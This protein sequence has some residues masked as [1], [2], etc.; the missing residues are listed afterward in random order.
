MKTSNE[1]ARIKLNDC[2]LHSITSIDDLQNRLFPN[3]GSTQIERA[4]KEKE[5]G[6]T[7]KIFS[8]KQGKKSRVVEDPTG[9]TKIIHNKVYKLI[10]HIETPDYLYS[11]V[12][13]KSYISNAKKHSGKTKLLKIDIGSFYQ[14]IKKNKLVDFFHETLCC[15][16]DVAICL[17]K[18]LTVNDH[19]S[20]GSPLSPLLSFWVNK[21]MFDKMHLLSVENG[22]K[23]SLYIDD[24]TF[25]GDGLN[26]N[27]LHK[28][29]SIINQSGFKAHKIRKYHFNQPKV[30]TGVCI[31]P[32]NES[33][34]PYKNQAKMKKLEKEFRNSIS[35]SEKSSMGIKLQGMYYAA[36]Q[37][38]N[39]FKVVGHKFHN[40]LQN[41]CLISND[42]IKPPK[43]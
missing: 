25:S 39:R 22:L 28:V 30:V 37:I 13:G 6:K 27:F 31:T 20:T 36:G 16:K 26:G 8:I 5:I 32:Q 17:A 43:T 23:M 11:A 40:E 24:V 10:K 9:L 38:E 33:L 14:S 41:Q 15:R 29:K 19:I 18:L 4:L 12:K 34:V 7:Y 42:K 1:K 2:F 3:D 35:C 21:K